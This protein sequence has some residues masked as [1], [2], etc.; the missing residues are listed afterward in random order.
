MIVTHRSQELTDGADSTLGEYV[1]VSVAII[2]ESDVCSCPGAVDVLEL[3]L[4]YLQRFG[5]VGVRENR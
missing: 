1:K 2:H 5:H 3:I 4:Q